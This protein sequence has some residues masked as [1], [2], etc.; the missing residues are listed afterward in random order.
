[1]NSQFMVGAAL[2]VSPVV[3]LS[4]TKVNAYIPKGTWYTTDGTSLSSTGAY[5]DLDAPLAHIPVHIRGGFILP[6]QHPNTTTEQSRKNPYYL[7]VA[8]DGDTNMADG[9]LYMDDGDSDIPKHSLIRFH[10]TANSLTSIPEMRDYNPATSGYSGV[11]DSVRIFGIKTAPNQVLLNNAA[12]SF[13]YNEA[14]KTLT[15]H[16]TANIMET[17]SL[18]WGTSGAS[19]SYAQASLL[20]LMLAIACMI[21]NIQN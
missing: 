3:T 15:A 10:A 17:F 14:T 11:V 20:G 4:A 5:F 18:S 13:Q 19:S 7:V 9:E 21:R 1:L 8:L 12:T 16:M 2:L 6:M